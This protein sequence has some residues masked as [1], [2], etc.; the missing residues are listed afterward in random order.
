MD[1]DECVW[2]IKTH[3]NGTPVNEVYD[4]CEYHWMVLHDDD[5]RCEHYESVFDNNRCD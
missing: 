1:C 3:Y 4:E 2:H 5:K